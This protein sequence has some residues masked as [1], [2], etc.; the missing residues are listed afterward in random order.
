MDISDLAATK[1]VAAQVESERR[2]IELERKR[3]RMEEEDKQAHLHGSTA[4]WRLLN[5]S[6]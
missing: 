1:D 2:I 6:G 3:L 5:S 4:G